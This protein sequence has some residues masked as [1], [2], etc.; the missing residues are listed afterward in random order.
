MGEIR[1][2]AEA[3]DAQREARAAQSAARVTAPLAV[4]GATPY[5]AIVAQD[6]LWLSRK[7][8]IPIAD[9]TMVYGHG[10][11]GKGRMLWSLIGSVT[12]GWPLG[13]DTAGSAPG[14]V[15]VVLPEDKPDEQGV[16]RAQAA[17]A[18]PGRVYDMTRL[19]GGGRFKLSAAAK[20]PGDVSRLHAFI[21]A[22]RDAGGNP[23]LVVL[24]PVAALVGWGTIQNNAGARRLME[25][26]QDMADATGVAVVMVAHETKAGV[27]QGSGGLRDAA[28]LIYHVT[29]APDNAGHRVISVEKANNLPPQED[30]RFA[31]VDDAQGNASVVWLDRSA[32]DRQRT[33]WR[34]QASA[35]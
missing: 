9:V 1:A 17:G 20:E 6:T 23:R 21:T 22:L 4:P 13:C 5:S 19:P 8:A 10:A 15:V 18:D 2:R 25:P 34:T 28:R 16:Q 31:V 32:I 26:V 29:R 7:P 14:D 12:Q 33:A 30:L 11:V 35:R 3:L 24:D 27:L